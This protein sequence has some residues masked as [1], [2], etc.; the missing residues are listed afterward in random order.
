MVLGLGIDLT[1]VERIERILAR[2][3]GHFEAKVFTDGERAYCHARARPAEHFAAR[4]AAKEAALKALGVPP[5][6][7][8]HELEVVSQPGLPPRLALT[9]E[10]AR[11]AEPHG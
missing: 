7:S 11:A 8:W 4:F 5:G 10:A 1:P 6:L 9:G 2:H 3:A